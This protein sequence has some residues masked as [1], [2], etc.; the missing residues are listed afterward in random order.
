RG[1]RPPL[2]PSAHDMVRESRIQG[3][4]GRRRFPVP[5]ILGVCR[6]DSVLGVP[7]YVMEHLHGVVVTDTEPDALRSP[8]GRAGT[9]AAVVDTLVALHSINVSDPEVAE[10]G[11]PEGYL[12]RQV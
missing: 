8:A 7:F 2:P 11:R 12:E 3:V 10:L 1:P 9:S 6:D 5:R 4:L